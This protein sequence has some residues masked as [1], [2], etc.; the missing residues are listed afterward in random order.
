[1]VNDCTHWVIP[2][3]DYLCLLLDTECAIIPALS[4]ASI[5]LLVLQQII[6]VNSYPSGVLAILV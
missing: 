6:S 1:M 2:A 5:S 3:L 4:V